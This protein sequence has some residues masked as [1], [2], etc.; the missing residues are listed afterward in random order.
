MRLKLEVGFGCDVRC[1]NQGRAI[2]LKPTRTRIK[3]HTYTRYHIY[4]K[5]SRP[6]VRCFETGPEG[7]ELED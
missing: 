2:L 3:A 5:K 7:P 4:N 6:Y 1:L